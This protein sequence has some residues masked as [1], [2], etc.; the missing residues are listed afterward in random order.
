MSET[1]NT[2]D[3]YIIWTDELKHQAV[4]EFINWAWKND[5]MQQNEDVWWNFKSPIAEQKELTTEELYTLYKSKNP[6]P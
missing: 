2:N 1:G 5:W 4:I 6:T 3:N